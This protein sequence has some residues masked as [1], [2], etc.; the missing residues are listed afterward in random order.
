MLRSETARGRRTEQ[1]DFE[2]AG[3]KPRRIVPVSRRGMTIVEVVVALGFLC[4]VLAGAYA[5]LTRSAAVMRA[6]RNHY[7]AV[8]LAR[9]RLERAQNLDYNTLYLLRENNVLVDENGAPSSVGGFRRSTWVD[10]NYVMTVGTGTNLMLVTNTYITV[11]VEI[12]NVRTGV[13]AGEKEE[14]SSVFTWYKT[15]YGGGAP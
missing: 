13:F 11:Q 3:M 15:P 12:R 2:A 10:T 8:T 5:M 4:L 6:A 7:V 14:L 9:N 1:R